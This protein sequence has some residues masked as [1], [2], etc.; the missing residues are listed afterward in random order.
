MIF[1]PEKENSIV[2]NE[3]DVGIFIFYQYKE[4]GT[5]SFKWGKSPETSDYSDP[6]YIEVTE[7]NNEPVLACSLNACSCQPQLR[8]NDI[9]KKWYCNCSSS[10]ICTKNEDQDEIDELLFWAKGEYTEEK[11]FFDDPIGAILCWN[12]QTAED[13]KF[14]N[15]KMLKEYK[16][17]A[18][19]Q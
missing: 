13:Y 5:I 9:I 2:W 4:L 14:I 3:T 7:V 15:E 19:Q 8:Y 16:S 12:V 1:V 18:K 11:G 17:Y 6:F 10:A